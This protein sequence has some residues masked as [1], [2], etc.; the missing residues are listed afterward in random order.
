MD[1]NDATTATTPIVVN[2][3]TWTTITNDGLGAFTNKTYSPSGV[4]DLLDVGT[5]A[6]DASE[7]SLGDTLLVRLDFTIIPSTNNQIA[8]VRYSL[9]TGGGSYTLEKTLPRLDTGSGQPYRTALSLDMIYLGDAN[10]MDNPIF[11]QVNT[12]GNS[13]I[14]NAGVVIQVV[15]Y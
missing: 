5:G 10:T 9:G 2:A 14:T 4:S 6:I 8:Q 12:S 13:T 1:Y 15:K 3:G 7:L 11:I